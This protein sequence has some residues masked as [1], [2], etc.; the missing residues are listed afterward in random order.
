MGKQ[1][2]FSFFTENGINYDNVE[3]PEVFT[4]DAMMPYLT[5]VKGAIGKNLFL[6]DKKTKAWINV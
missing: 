5:N 3:H 2:L 4:V 1:E 6:K